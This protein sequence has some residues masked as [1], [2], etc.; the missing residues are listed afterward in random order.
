MGI[1]TSLVLFCSHFHQVKDDIA[2][3]KRSPIARLGTKRG[4]EVFGM[5]YR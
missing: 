4:A 3:G 5:V 1:V 2:A